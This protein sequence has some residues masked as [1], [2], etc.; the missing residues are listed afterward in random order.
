[1]KRSRVSVSPYL[2][3]L[4]LL[5][6]L[7]CAGRGIRAPMP[8]FHGHVVDARTG[9]PIAGAIVKRRLYESGPVNFVDGERP[10][11]VKGGEAET[12]SDA[13]G[14]FVLPPFKPLRY[15]GMAWLVY[16]PGW[17]P[18]YSCYSDAGWPFSGCSGFG[19]PGNDPWTS[20]HITK[21]GD[22]VDLELCVFPPTLE[23]VTFRSYNVYTK[24][25]ATFTPTPEQS[26][27]W[28]HYFGRLDDLCLQQ[29]LPNE[30]FVHQAVQY[31]EHNTPSEGAVSR[32]H[33]FLS[34]LG[35]E[36]SRRPDLAL[37]LAKIV[38]SYCM[39]QP[40]SPYCDRIAL[41]LKSL[42]RYVADRQETQ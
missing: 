4:V 17:M 1:M 16:K 38:V 42:R 41:P 35:S 34:N 7:G 21:H 23:G 25:W 37:P 11:N 5:M 40:Q 2:R 32:I 31:A 18:A 10:R 39:Q 20:V 29:W 12:T 8:E 24:Q 26:D 30:D 27:P 3:P 28:N 6:A 36:H 13:D 14:R 33:M 22:R 9:A 15:T 19:M